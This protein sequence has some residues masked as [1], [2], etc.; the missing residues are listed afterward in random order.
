MH[1]PSMR[2]GRRR[3]SR[4][5]VPR[6]VSRVVSTCRRG[7]ASVAHFMSLFTSHTSAT[8]YGADGKLHK[9][10][11]NLAPIRQRRANAR[12]GRAIIVVPHGRRG[13]KAVGA[14]GE[15]LSSKGCA[16]GGVGVGNNGWHRFAGRARGTPHIPRARDAGAPHAR[17]PLRRAFG[18][19]SSSSCALFTSLASSSLS[20]PL[21]PLERE[22]WRLP[23]R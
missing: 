20:M 17:P 9:S 22:T 23:V 2:A 19:L 3:P 15:G 18:L 4:G 12:R 5:R 16:E 11:S 1:A 13:R 7:E 14:L 21:Q 10:I 6:L 8:A